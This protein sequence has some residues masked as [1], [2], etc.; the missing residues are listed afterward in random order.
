MRLATRPSD[1]ALKAILDPRRLLRW[2]FIGRL[3]LA[4]AIF[5]AA[6]TNWTN[7][8]SSKTLIASLAFAVS[9]VVSVVSAAYVEI[10]GRRPGETF[11]YLQA[12]FDLLLLT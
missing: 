3:C 6:I 1:P 8:G 2:V 4:S 5:I 7:A 11:L 10:Y 9:T 12:A